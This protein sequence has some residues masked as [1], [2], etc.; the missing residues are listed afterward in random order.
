MS[1]S[2]VANPALL[3]QYQAKADAM[4]ESCLKSGNTDLSSITGTCYYISENGDD[5][6]DG[7]TPATPIRTLERV[8]A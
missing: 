1:R 7:L 2:L 3:A 8:N 5:A 4:K 6:N